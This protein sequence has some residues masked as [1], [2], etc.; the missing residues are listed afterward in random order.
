MRSSENNDK[1]N[2]ERLQIDACELNFQHLTN[3]NVANENGQDDSEGE[4]SSE[5]ISH[6]MTL[7]LPDYIS[8]RGF[9]YSYITATREI[10][11]ALLMRSLHSP[12]N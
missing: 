10:C 3:K 9:K 11:T 4:Q 1:D 6:R 7:L 5:C 12:Q 8:H 2:K